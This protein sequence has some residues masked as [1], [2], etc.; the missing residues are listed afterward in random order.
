MK[1]HEYDARRLFADRGLPVPPSTLAETAEQAEIAARDIAGTVVIKAQVLA[2][3][4]GKAGGVK[5]AADPVQARV[6]AGEILAMTI[7]GEPVGKVLIAPSVDIDREIYLGAVIDRSREGVSLMASA[8]G[9]VDIEEVTKMAPE[10]IRH[11]T[12]DPALGLAPWE[13]RALGFWL[14]LSGRQVTQ[15]TGVAQGLVRTVLDVDATLAEVNP[16]VVDTSGQLHAIDAK[17]NLDDSG[18]FRHPELAAL[19]DPQE[20]TAAESSAREAGASYIK[21]NGTIGCMVN[22]AGLAMATMDVIKHY[23]G[24]PA[25]FLDVGGGADR[26][27]VATAFRI[28]LEDPNVRTVFVNIFGGITRADDVARGI[29]DAREAMP[30]KVPLVVRLVGTNEDHGLQ[31]LAD[32]GLNAVRSMEEAAKLAV[33]A[34]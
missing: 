30:R 10:S 25:N 8:E 1:L 18:L 33:A 6:I 2:G 27:K 3:G 16:L 7:H 26:N 34:S 4:R 5:I 12:V 24:E 29:L 13:A 20:E 17:I 28:I 23:G 22:G 14:G 21:L 11:L 32:A 9:G 31:L 19:R 15:F